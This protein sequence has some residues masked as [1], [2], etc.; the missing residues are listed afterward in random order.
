MQCQAGQTSTVAATSSG[1]C[2]DT[3]VSTQPYD[4]IET[5]ASTWTNLDL[6]YS[7]NAS[8]AAAQCKNACQAD[9]LCQYW[10]FRAAQSDPSEDGCQLK[11]APIEPAADTYT[12]V[13]LAT[14]DY[15]IW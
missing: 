12:S 8:A 11:M 5:P 7:L 1:D 4:F 9:D 15:A 2:F 14:G 13:K 10:R 6:G 3:F